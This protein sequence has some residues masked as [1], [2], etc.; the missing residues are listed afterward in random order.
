MRNPAQTFEHRKSA[1]FHH[2]LL[3]FATTYYQLWET[4]AL[5]RKPLVDSVARSLLEVAIR[6]AIEQIKCGASTENTV[7]S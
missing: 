1:G 7:Q 3:R 5:K 6:G 2:T 4:C